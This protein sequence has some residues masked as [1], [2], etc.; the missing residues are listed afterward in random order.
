MSLSLVTGPTGEPV[1]LTEVKAQLRLDV[2]E[3][4]GF[5]A[6]CVLAAREWVEGQTKRVLMRS[7]WDYSIDEGWPFRRGMYRIDLPVNPVISV[8]SISYVDDTGATQTLSS[9]LYTAVCREDGSYV[10]VAYNKSLPTIR[11]VPDAITVRFTAGYVDDSVSPQVNAVPWPLHR[12]ICM[13]AGHFYENREAASQKVLA[14]VPFAV[15]ALIS[16]Y[17]DCRV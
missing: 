17:R 1:T 12:A 9:S 2:A 13:L 3:D 11:N 6:G 5:L 8:D 7:T 10:T 4:D 14:E 16:P 15:E